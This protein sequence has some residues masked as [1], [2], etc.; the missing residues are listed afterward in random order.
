MGLDPASDASFDL[1]KTWIYLCES[2]H[3]QC[4]QIV[5]GPRPRRLVDVGNT[6]PS[7]PPRLVEDCPRDAQ[8]I[9]LSHCWGTGNTF[10]TERSNLQD[11]KEG[12]DWLLY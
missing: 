8:Y 2:D 5:A 11:R 10:I 7:I 3:Q 6:D 9:A 4:K 12:M 1:I